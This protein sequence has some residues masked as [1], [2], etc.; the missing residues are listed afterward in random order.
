MIVR[1]EKC[2][3]TIDIKSFLMIQAFV[4]DGMPIMCSKCGNEIYYKE[5]QK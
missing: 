1:C 2:K 4:K 3:E 5:E